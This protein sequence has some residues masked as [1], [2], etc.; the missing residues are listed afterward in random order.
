MFNDLLEKGI[1]V[2]EESGMTIDPKYCWY[3]SVD[4]YPL[5]KCITLK[6]HIM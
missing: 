3:H 4:T 2:L 1:V 5:R 6:E